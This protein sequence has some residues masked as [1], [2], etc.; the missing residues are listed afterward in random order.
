MPA[1]KLSRGSRGAVRCVAPARGEPRGRASP[2]RVSR[3]GRPRQGLPRSGPPG[4]ASRAA[5]LLA[6]KTP[7]RAAAAVTGFN[8]ALRG[9]HPRLRLRGVGARA[10]PRLP[11]LLEHPLV[12]EGRS[13]QAQLPPPAVRGLALRT[14]RMRSAALAAALVS[15]ATAGGERS[16]VLTVYERS[17]VV[18]G[19]QAGRAGRGSAGSTEPFAAAAKL[20][21]CVSRYSFPCCSETVGTNFVLSVKIRDV[22]EGSEPFAA[23]LGSPV[24]EAR[25]C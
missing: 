23:P 6:L 16:K 15:L 24:E 7:L 22:V 3:G 12:G 9:S 11:A 10:V 25:G 4:G 1:A 19:K 2:G 21:R 13:P 14:R 8:R 20:L 18:P 17:Q 5:P